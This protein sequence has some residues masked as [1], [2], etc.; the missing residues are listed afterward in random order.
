MA[1][2]EKER[3]KKREENS[4][5]ICNKCIKHEANMFGYTN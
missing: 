4:R 1:K 2:G 3:D 5:K